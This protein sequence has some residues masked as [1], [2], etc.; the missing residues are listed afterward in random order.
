GNLN[1]GLK[2]S[3]G[4]LVAV[5][6]C[7]HVP[8]RSFLR[9]TT[10]FFKDQK[11]AFVQTPFY[12]INSDPFQQALLLSRDIPHEEQLFFNVIEPGL[13][14]YGAA[15]SCGTGVI[16]RRSALS[17]VSGFKTNMSAIDLH[18]S[19]L[20]HSKGW[21][22]VYLNQNL[23]LHTSAE[24]TKTF[25][26]NR[27][28]RIRQA[29]KL[30]LK[31]L[32]LWPKLTLGQRLG[33]LSLLLNDLIIFP[34]LVFMIAPMA[35]L[36]GLPPIVAP[37]KTF[38]G[39]FMP[40]FISQIIAR[41]ILANYHRHPLWSSVYEITDISAIW[42][43]VAKTRQWFI[44]APSFPLLVLLGIQILGLGIG[45]F[46][47]VKGA[48]SWQLI[49]LGG[50]WSLY[51]LTLL[52][53][54]A[55]A[56]HGR[57][58]K[59]DNPRI[60]RAG[61]CTL[62]G[63]G[64]K[65]QAN[66]VDASETGLSLN[67]ATPVILP[68][69]IEIEIGRIGEE[70]LILK[71]KIKRNETFSYGASVGIRFSSMSDMQKHKLI[72]WLY[73]PSETWE[74]EES[75]PHT[76]TI[77]LLGLLT[78]AA[79]AFIRESDLHRSAPRYSAALPCRLILRDRV[80]VTTTIDVS[81][82]GL[83][84]KAEED[85]G[86]LSQEMALEIQVPGQSVSG[87]GK[88]VWSSREEDHWK[89]GI[90]LETESGLHL[91]NALIPYARLK[92]VLNDSL[93]TRVLHLM[94]RVAA[95]AISITMAGITVAIFV[96]IG[97]VQLPI[98]PNLQAVYNFFWLFLFLILADGLKVYIEIMHRAIPR[99]YESDLSQITVLI[100]CRNTGKAIEY[101]IEHLR[102]FIPCERIIIIDDASTD[103]TVEVARRMG[104][105]V[106]SLKENM[107]KP[108]AIETGLQWVHTQYTLLLD[109]DSRIQNMFLPTSLLEEGNT[110]VAF[111]VLPCRRKR[112]NF[113][114][115]N[116]VSCLQRYEYAKSMEIGK[117]FQD[118]TLSVSCIS[119]AAGLFKTDRLRYL[120]PLH[121]NIF[122]GEDLE[123]TLI[124]LL[125]GGRIAFANEPVWTVSPDNWKDLTRQRL[126]GWNPGF[127]RLSGYYLK[128]L[129]NPAIPR[130][131]KFEMLYNFYVILSDPLKVLSFLALIVNKF[132]A[133]LAFLYLFYLALEIYPFIT[134]EK[135][136]PVFRYY[137]PALFIYPAYGIYNT[138][139]R[140]VSLFI[141][142]WRRYITKKWKPRHEV[143][144]GS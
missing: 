78:A 20:F 58:Q 132:W 14:R 35:F 113:D 80:I 39:Y 1:N 45:L 119:G 83:L 96:R 88:P 70:T 26:R 74:R 66:I 99:K 123:R 59:R 114:G 41:H 12:N 137:L 68:Q 4:D 7:D 100:P 107:G 54:G 50:F 25:F 29:F 102:R 17:E 51:N 130:R 11:V 87:R 97:V 135:K 19:A 143:K 40:F 94:G 37:L 126:F 108:K 104:A 61:V 101:T 82:T 141:W 117:R 118:K 92:V 56:A 72:L 142:L 116:F 15:V 16:Y 65:W 71:G 90:H 91:L 89:I 52:T 21:H 67:M 120:Q 86:P 69:E 18:L 47:S 63:P 13:D 144:Y 36:L 139:L 85:P 48:I 6:D 53:A 122:P 42:A 140:F 60:S 136:L 64:D 133:G 38:L 127:Y 138:F 31:G 131:L 49:L 103:N 62:I 81:S 46:L 2:Y 112:E 93:Q 3:T 33:Y 111:Y 34:R 76:H 77:A 10:G 110:G 121:S 28:N 24:E 124:D 134:V 57:S 105:Q 84:L 115:K 125:N 128:I 9:E 106:Y 22:S 98:S 32:P 44:S 95:Y 73:C 79:R 30:F 5:F 43:S 75:T 109:D 27:A 129:F 8:V 55:A 23:A